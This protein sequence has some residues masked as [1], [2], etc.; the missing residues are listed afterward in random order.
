M[1]S[2]DDDLLRIRDADRIDSGANVGLA[3]WHRD[4]HMKPLFARIQRSWLSDRTTR[5]TLRTRRRCRPQLGIQS[6][7]LES[8]QLLANISASAVISSAP[9]GP[10]FN[11]TIKLTNSAQSDSSIGTFWYAWIP[12]PDQNYL[13]TSPLSVTPP[14]GWT[15]QITHDGTGDGFGIEFVSSSA[16]NNVQPGKSLSFSFTSA[17]TPASVN[18]TSQFHAGARVGTSFVYPQGPFSDGG[19]ELIVAPAPTVTLQ[20]IKVIP[21]N[22]AIAQGKNEQFTAIGTFS[23]HTT[24]NLTSQVTWASAKGSVATISPAGLAHGVA[25]GSSSISAKLNGITGATVLKVLPPLHVVSITPGS[26]TVTA[27]PG[28]HVV[29]T[30]N[31]PLAG[32][33][34]DDPTGGGFTAH[35]KAVTLV[36]ENPEGT[37]LPATG[38][39]KGSRPIHATLVYHVNANGTSTITLIPQEPLGTDQ[40]Q[41]N[42]SGTLTGIAGN[43]LTTTGGATGAESAQFELMT[44]A[45]NATPIT[46]NSITTLRGSV[47]IANG[48]SIPQPDTIA[49]TFN[50]PV[51]FLTVNSDTVQLLAGPGNTPVTTAVAYNPTTKTVYLTPED[52]LSPGTTYT[53]QVSG[54]ISDNQSF[55]NPNPNI[56][57]GAAVT[58]TFEVKS[59]GA[60]GKGPLVA[61]SKNGHLLATPAFGTPRT[62]PLGYA[63]VPFSETVDL[64]TLG[65]NSVTLTPQKGGLNNK[66][67]D[68]ADAPLNVRVAFN[69][70]TNTMIIV[71]TV[72]V[73]N[74]TY[75]Y[76][77]SNM[78]AKNGD[79]LTHP[80]GSLPVTDTFVVN[81]PAKPPGAKAAS[82]FV[83]FGA[84]TTEQTE[85]KKHHGS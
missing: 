33:K 83:S 60:T 58:R 19:H 73:G 29:V 34:A 59:V 77:L 25:A 40:Y 8:R 36:P 65:P 85:N 20:S 68:A 70:N 1:S 78:K 2:F 7:L 55:P 27:L 67:F 53:I 16:I 44:V 48:A 18:G 64:A 81:V 10:N 28:G 72:L 14:Q 13:A 11:Y 31:Q 76:S 74:D 3:P 6:E 79:P 5:R 38:F 24:K 30:F 39:N 43:A 46:V 12:S 22:P 61:L 23:D 45:Q 63:S 4:P 21:A 47:A 71:P 69:P 62:A 49:I 9:A 17:D 42:I 84:I 51:D 26:G 15:D 75:R 54:T 41:V 82:S 35:P 50:K 37:F 32:L 56:T 80:G 52:I 57:L 66:A